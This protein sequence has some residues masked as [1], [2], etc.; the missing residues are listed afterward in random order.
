MYINLVYFWQPFKVGQYTISEPVRDLLFSLSLFPLQTIEEGV[1]IIVFYTYLQK[2]KPHELPG[3]YSSA[4]SNNINLLCTAFNLNISQINKYFSSVQF[5][6]PGFKTTD[7][8]KPVSEHDLTVIIRVCLD[9]IHKYYKDTENT[10]P[11]SY[12]T[13]QKNIQSM[14]DYYTNK[15]NEWNTTLKKVDVYKII[16]LLFFIE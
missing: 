6:S 5:I 8:S 12:C 13:N 7:F 11:E 4:V 16:I 3:L 2:S 14:K 9:M 10:Y 15:V 1:N